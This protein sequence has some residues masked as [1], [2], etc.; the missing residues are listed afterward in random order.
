MG[1]LIDT[2]FHLDHYK[3]YNELVTQINT[4]QQYTICVTNSPGVFHSCKNL[5][6]ESKYLKFA[7]GFHPQEK[8]LTNQDLYNFMRLIDQTNYVG[9]IGI[10]LSSSSYRN[11]D[12]QIDYFDQIVK[13]CAA[14]NKLMTVHIRRAEEQALKIIT[15]YSPSKC[16]IHWFTGT[17]DQL[18]QFID[19]G[20]Y[21]SV[22]TNMVSGKANHKYLLIPLDRLL[23]ES[24]GP[25]TRVNGKRYTPAFLQDSYLQIAQFY[26]D[27]DFIIHVYNNFKQL[28]SS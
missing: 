19:A 28:L 27:P 4:L 23:V 20:C 25:Y 16:I 24:D 22:N 6:S 2:H 7:I 21:F 5:I 13:T 11:K 17:T 15:K 26:N 8:A 1:Y 3:N 9:E 10:D 18:Q 12:A 14:K